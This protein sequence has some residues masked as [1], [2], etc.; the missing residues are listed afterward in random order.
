MAT[1]PR[2][3]FLQLCAAVS[4]L[5]ATKTRAAEPE[6]ELGFSLY[7]MKSLS[8]ADA[9]RTCAEI[10]YKNVELP[11]NPGFPTELAALTDDKRR[12]LRDLLAKNHLRVSALMLNLSLAATDAQHA[13]NVARIVAAG[14]LA[15]E[16][17]AEK[18]PLIETVLGGKPAE[19]EALKEKMA[20]RLR[21]WAQAAEEAKTTVAL[22][23]HVG[24]AVNSPERLL[25]LLEQVKSPAIVV[26][27]DYSHFELAGLKLDETLRSLLPQTRFIHVKDTTGDSA[28]FQFLLPGQGRTDYGAYFAL[29]RE[30]GY[31]GPIV[32]EVSAQVFNKPGYDPVQA[33]RESYAAL[34]PKL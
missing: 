18:P 22:K 21:G 3:R 6:L 17:D 11:L 33:A 10:G 2:R 34:A 25:W 16:L 1:L 7:G 29:L 19:W 12:E 15:H 20:E 30:H 28:K 5:C 13:D 24:S 26:G 9:L 4:A 14:K 23:A 27:Y 31:R 8:L 32:V